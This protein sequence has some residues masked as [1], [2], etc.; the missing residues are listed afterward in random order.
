MYYFILILYDVINSL[1]PLFTAAFLYPL[2]THVVS[3]LSIVNSPDP[4]LLSDVFPA[5]GK[6]LLN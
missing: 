3:S 4:L 2:Q 6:S 5:L 1:I